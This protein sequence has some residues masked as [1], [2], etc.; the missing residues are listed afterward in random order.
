MVFASLAS[1]LY[2]MCTTIF[3]IHAHSTKPCRFC[4]TLLAHINIPSFMYAWLPF[5]SNPRHPQH[6]LISAFQWRNCWGWQLLL[7]FAI[8][9]M[10]KSWGMNHSYYVDFVY[11]FSF[12]LE[13]REVFYH[14]LFI[15]RCYYSWHVY[16]IP[17]RST[18]A[19]LLTC[20]SHHWTAHCSIFHQHHQWHLSH[21]LW[22]AVAYSYLHVGVEATMQVRDC[23]CFHKPG[24]TI[25]TC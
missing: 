1:P 2:Y 19:L 10:C 12:R 22:L 18:T 23:V 8:N 3:E 24:K 25:A 17:C 4:M 21:W 5:Y 16:K 7:H 20:L 13:K 15:S 9:C 6:H 14:N 11:L